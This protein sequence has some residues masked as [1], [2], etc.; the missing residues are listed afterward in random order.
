[1]IW[2]RSSHG[3]ADCGVWS[4]LASIEF[5]PLSHPFELLVRMCLE[6]FEFSARKAGQL[7]HMAEESGYTSHPTA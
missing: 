1:M 3:E 2:P 4:Q 5:V 6:G 7:P